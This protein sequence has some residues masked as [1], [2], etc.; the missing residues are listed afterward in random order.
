MPDCPQKKRGL[1]GGETGKDV[2]AI[3][4]AVYKALDNAGGKPG[5]AR[6]GVCGTYTQADLRA[7]QKIAG[8]DPTGRMGQPTLESLWPFFDA[9]GRSIYLKAKI[10]KASQLPGG[11]L[12]SGAKGPRVR[13]A[14]QMLWRALGDET[15]NIRNSVYGVGVESDVR[16]FC[17]IADLGKVSGKEISQ[18]LWEMM[19]A[20]GD[21]YAQDLASAAPSGA[22]EIRSN[23]VTW[24]EW[25]VRNRGSYLQARP[26]QRDKPP[27]TP[28]RNDCSGSIHHLF[29]LAGGPDPSGRSFDGTGYT[30][31]MQT[32]GTRIPLTGRLL[33][34]DCIFYGVQ[35]G[36]V[37][38]HVGMMLD[39]QRLF[40]FGV[41]PPTIVSFALYWRSG[42]RADIGA[43]RY[44]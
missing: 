1:T 13:A 18:N 16:H 15:D 29:K 24:A 17:G 20:F 28:L 12:V 43:R 26:Y 32:R 8:I 34:G 44:I 40:T 22:S 10:G 33:A 27:V 37:A 2:Q 19:W 42:Q 23:L 11:K 3:Q 39:A 35:A 4:R 6:N 30:G 9:F 5:N 7:W 25:Y 31:T 36:G 21:A 14:Q 41:T 38:Q